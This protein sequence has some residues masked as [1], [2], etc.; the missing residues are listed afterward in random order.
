MIV[1]ELIYDKPTVGVRHRM[2]LRSSFLVMST[3]RPRF[4]LADTMG[5]L[6]GC[7]FYSSSFGLNQWSL[8]P[9]E[10]CFEAQRESRRRGLCCLPRNTFRWWW[11]VSDGDFRAL[12]SVSKPG[13]GFSMLISHA[14]LSMFLD[15]CLF[16]WVYAILFVVISFLHLIS[17]VFIREGFGSRIDRIG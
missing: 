9:M 10:T 3:I 5:M 13:R 11:V 17:F 12:G 4:P 7:I 16:V 6:Y 14:S 15:R 8:G 2:A 1:L